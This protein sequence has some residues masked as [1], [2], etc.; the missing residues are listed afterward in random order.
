V[1]KAG[2]AYVPLDAAYP[3][4]RLAFM[5]A[6]S[7]AEIVLIDGRDDAIHGRFAPLAEL[8][9]VDG[10]VEEGAAAELPPA[11]PATA[12][13]L[14]I[15]TSGSTGRPKGVM[16][17]HRGVVRLVREAAHLRSAPGDRVAHAANIS[18]DAATLE[19]WGALLNGSAL[20]VVPRE[21]ALAPAE[22][23]ARLR[24]ER[25]TTLFLTTALFNQVAWEEPAALAAP[26]LR[27]VMF[28]G[29]AADPEA[30]A[31]VL[32]EGGGP[33]RLLHLYGPAEST[34]LA[35]WHRVTEVRPG[36]ATVPIGL[37]VSNS[38]VYVLDRFQGLAAPGAVG[39]L[40]AGGDGL[41]R[42]YLNR[43]EL[44]AG[45]FIPHPWAGTPGERLYRTG[46]LVRQRPDGAIEFVGRADEQVKI[47]GFR[48]EPGEI[49]AV[50][51]SH[52]QVRECAVV[53][54][55][56]APGVRTLVA[57]GTCDPASPP[58]PA[59]LRAFLAARLP[60][61]M[62]P[63][64]FVRLDALPLTPNGKLDRAALPAPEPGRAERAGGYAAPR[65]LV[66]ETLAAIWADLLRIE[67]VDARDNFFDLGGH[68]LLAT[69]VMVAVWNQLGVRL[70]VR[71]LFLHPT[72][73]GLAARLE[74]GMLD[75]A[76]DDRLSELLDLLDNEDD[77]AAP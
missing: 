24:Q 75:K 59:E 69:R 12:L 34:T 15:Y 52:P 42:G 64:A 71:E 5:L 53:A 55:E 50:L 49:E 68:S 56:D 32:A 10:A 40:C 19:I 38:T 37:P 28:G 21:V 45:R 11:A 47:R 43:P 31:R 58:D 29:E 36:A 33:A 4:E 77:E 62:L 9:A 17:T 7:G 63:R 39:E 65:G 23:A 13:A 26:P 6:D 73:E 1:L 67:K 22:L 70:P 35:T 61:H 14:V 30:V 2:G 46:D 20:V 16:L 25:V 41:A 18:F 51:A 57:Y 76:G 72:L 60:D 3:D 66:A 74:Q 27:T 48:I 44:T 54:R 8:L